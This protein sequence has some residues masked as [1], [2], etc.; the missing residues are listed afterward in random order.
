MELPAP[1]HD[2]FFRALVSRSERTAALMQEHLPPEIAALI[3][4]ECPPE[5][6]EGSFVDGEGAKMQCDALFR[7]RLKGGQDAR[8][9]ALLEHKSHVDRRTPLQLAR[10]RLNIWTG[11][12][13]TTLA[14]RKLPMILPIV[15]L[16]WYRRVDSSFV[17][18]R[19]D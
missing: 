16:S 11:E 9:F 12:L 13:E 2:A 14:H 8:I 17:T 3:D 6:M 10:Y 5:Q 19:D 7:V 1:H 15:F 4:F 18:G